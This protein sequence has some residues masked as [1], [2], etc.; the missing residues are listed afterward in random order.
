[1]LARRETLDEVGLLDEHYYT[2]FCESD[3]AWRM[4]KA[5]WRV[6]Y[7]PDHSIVHVGGEHSINTAEKQPIQIVRAFANRFHY[8]TK[9]H[10]RVA[11]ALLRPITAVAALVRIARWGVA[12]IASPASREIARSRVAGFTDVVK[13]CFARDPDVLPEKYRR[14]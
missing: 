11:H 14:S 13:L 7:V 4:Q 8:F 2:Y 9:H 1:M 5:G 10:G 12:G 6:V 3:W